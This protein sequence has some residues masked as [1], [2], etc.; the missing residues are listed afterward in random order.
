MGEPRRLI[1]TPRP[2]TTPET[3]A[4]ALSAVYRFLLQKRMRAPKG[5]DVRSAHSPAR[6]EVPHEPVEN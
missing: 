6:K 2:D 4:A 3:E 1:Y 5:T